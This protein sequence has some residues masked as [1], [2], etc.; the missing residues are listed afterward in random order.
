MSEPQPFPTPQPPRPALMPP[1]HTRDLT[2]AIAAFQSDT[3]PLVREELG[4]LAREGQR[5]TRLF[6][7]CSD[8]RLITSM[9]TSSGPGDMFT[10]RNVGNLVPPPGT[11]DACDSVAAAIEYAVEILRV[12]SITVC[13]H[14][15]CGAIQALL[16]TAP[17]A[18]A[19]PPAPTTGPAPRPAA[20]P[21]PTSAPPSTPAP[22]P[23]PTPP[24]PP[25]PLPAPSPLSRWL[26]H[27]HASL[28]RLAAT[29]A[30]SAPRPGATTTWLADPQR[31]LADRPAA[32]EAERLC[33]LNVVQ[34]L[35]HLMAH[36]CVARGVA[37]GELQLHGMYFHVAEAQGYLLD[38]ASGRFTAVRPDTSRAAPAVP[39]A[40]EAQGH[41]LGETEQV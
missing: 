37:A 27:G 22:A 3:A 38:D 40:A 23:A 5:P 24:L 32:D 14:S 33:L 12:G 30:T 19:A 7:S 15:G 8:S 6:L 35:D 34:Q 9:I 1:H 26:R 21:A 4:R 16:D 29:P 18:P 36:P 28:L 13:G 2:S 25:T 31:P 41:S 17:P 39:W 20:A 10:V 11:D